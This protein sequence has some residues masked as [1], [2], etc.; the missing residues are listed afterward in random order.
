MMSR[1][2]QMS[3]RSPDVNARCLSLKILQMSTLTSGDIWRRKNYQNRPK[4]RSKLSQMD[5][6]DTKKDPFYTYRRIQI[7]AKLCAIPV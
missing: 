3:R 2:A 1:D 6:K 5:P 4:M 7:S